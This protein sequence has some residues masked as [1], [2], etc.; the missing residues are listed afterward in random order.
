V[1]E[2]YWPA[3]LAPD[4]AV[5]TL[6]DKFC[7]FLVST[8]CS[9]IL[10]L[11]YDPAVETLLNC[12]K[13]PFIRVVGS[14][15]RWTDPIDS[16]AILVWKLHG[17]LRAPSTIVLSPTEYQF[18]Y[19]VNSLGKELQKLGGS[20]D[21]LWSFGVGLRDDDVWSYICTDRQ[22]SHVVALW[23][24][25]KERSDIKDWE[26]SVVRE[27]RR[28]T[29]L[30]A[31]PT[32]GAIGSGFLA[33]QIATVQDVLASTNA[34]K[35]RNRGARSAISAKF[36]DAAKD[37]QERYDE[38]RRRSRP[39]TQLALIEEYRD[40]YQQLK[41]LLLSQVAAGVGETW[42]SGLVRQRQMGKPSA[43]KPDA[44]SP[45]TLKSLASDFRAVIELAASWCGEH[46]NPGDGQVLTLIASAAQS[47]VVHVL[48]LADML[49]V[50]IETTVKRKPLEV[51]PVLK[52]AQNSRYIVGCNPFEAPHKG[53][54][55]L[56]HRFEVISGSYLLQYPLLA[57]E[58]GEGNKRLLSED[59]WET[60]V[61][62]LYRWMTPQLA[63]DG[64]SI[65]NQML[66]SIPPLYP[67]GFRFADI[68][69]YRACATILVSKIWSLVEGFDGEGNQYCK[70][71]GLRDR[72][73]RAFEIGTRG[74]LRIGEY[75]DFVEPAVC[76]S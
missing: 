23:C 66:T 42:C 65:S 64:V 21:T 31:K 24:S 10:D 14:E 36:I 43:L 61:L 34:L 70:G 30:H 44:F 20:L 46:A 29:V 13:L 3:D 45:E 63:V 11:N 71:G 16:N 72:A 73:S 38:L 7:D 19:E 39:L 6:A 25:G 17:S 2:G 52:V 27:G 47:A 51:G 54:C 62:F 12:G 37:F 40:R 9:L 35:T 15:Y 76:A 4:S 74:L 60:A 57:R 50:K 49:G 26:E 18:I 32:A 28:V 22:P 67:W 75:D 8:S 68:R 58:G 59:E 69:D 41:Q 33:Q 1:L 56:M 48:D 5:K 55:N 53:Q